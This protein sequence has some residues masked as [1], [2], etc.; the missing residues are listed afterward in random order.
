MTLDQP[1][2]ADRQRASEKNLERIS[3]YARAFADKSG[4][5]LHPSLR[6]PSFS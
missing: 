6:S 5:F 3:R 2:D 4:T 1:T